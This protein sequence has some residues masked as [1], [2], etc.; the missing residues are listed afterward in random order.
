MLDAPEDGVQ[1][2]IRVQ[3]LEQRPAGQPLEHYL[4]QTDDANLEALWDKLRDEYGTGTYRIRI[5]KSGPGFSQQVGQI[6]RA[7]KSFRVPT[8]AA[9]ATPPA[10]ASA[11]LGATVTAALERQ[12]QL[13]LQAIE[14]LAPKQGGSDM[15]DS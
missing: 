3:L 8:V 12:Q 10:P 13:F 5:R 2:L 1:Y 7:I 4:F 11:D 6:D 14:R 9:P 15:T